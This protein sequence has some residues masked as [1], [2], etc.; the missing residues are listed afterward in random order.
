[1]KEM[2]RKN[3]THNSFQQYDKV[4]A[5]KKKINLTERF[6]PQESQCVKLSSLL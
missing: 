2:S 1:M 3:L 5:I 4:Y 6:H